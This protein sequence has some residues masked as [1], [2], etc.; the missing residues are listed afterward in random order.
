MDVA[1]EMNSTSVKNL[2]KLAILN[3]VLR[4]GSLLHSSI[5]LAS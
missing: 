5:K 1:A 3:I 4:F 2:E